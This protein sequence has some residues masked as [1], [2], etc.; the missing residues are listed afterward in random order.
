MIVAG[1]EKHLMQ[2][3]ELPQ[4]LLVRLQRGEE[5]NVR[6][7]DTTYIVSYVDWML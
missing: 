2:P 4:L 3:T 6:E 5:E 1:D 7:V